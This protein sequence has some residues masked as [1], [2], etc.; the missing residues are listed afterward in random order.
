MGREFLPG[1]DLFD[2]ADIAGATTRLEWIVAKE[3]FSQSTL[4]RRFVRDGRLIGLMGL[5]PVSLDLAEGW[6]DIKPEAAPD[7]VW[8]CR[9]I[10][11][12]LTGAPYPAIVTVVRT[13]AG[14][15]IVSA[16]GFAF[17]ERLEAGDL[18]VR[19]GERNFRRGAEG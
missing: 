8:L 12:T 7:M 5:Y 3:Q 11:L 15:R 18:Y 10:R 6:F 14:A 16:C 17:H 2:L 1:A 19:S 9:Q 13:Q 4:I